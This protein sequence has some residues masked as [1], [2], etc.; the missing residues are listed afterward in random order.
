ME[1]GGCRLEELIA[2][3]KLVPPESFPAWL[4]LFFIN[5]KEGER[6]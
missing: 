6:A 5:K 4:A 1:D 2:I 3:T